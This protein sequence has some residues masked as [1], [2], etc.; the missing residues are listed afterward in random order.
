[1]TN[2]IKNTTLPVKSVPPKAADALTCKLTSAAQRARKVT[3]LKRLRTQV[4]EKQELP[5][6]YVFTFP[7]TD[8]MLSKLTDFIMTERACCDFFSFTLQVSGD[9]SQ[10]RLTLTGPAVAKD[11]IASEL[12]F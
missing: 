11:F 12:G 1:M 10:M 6:G 3:V 9:K 5:H 7:G 8:L 4:F 2:S